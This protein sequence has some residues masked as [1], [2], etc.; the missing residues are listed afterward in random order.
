VYPDIAVVTNVGE[1]HLEGFG[2][3]E[4]VRDTDLE[5]LS[6]VRTACINADDPLLIEGIGTY[7]GR[8]ITYGIENR[9]DFSAREIVPGEEG[10]RFLLV[11][12]DL[13]EVPV[14]LGISGR[15][16]VLNAVAAASAATVLGMN[17]EEI[18]SGL[19]SFRGV[20]MRLEI[21]RLSGALVINDVYNANPA[22]ME[23]ALRELVRLRKGRAIAVLGDMLELG[24]YAPDAHANLVRRLNELSV[25]IL[26]AVGPEMHKA[27]SGF[28]GQAHQAGSSSDARSLLLGMMQEGDTV[29][30]KGSRGMSMEKVLAGDEQAAATEHSNAL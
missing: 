30:I 25:D 1:A 19:E 22:S 6:Y 8:V 18:R 5:V 17:L 26:I 11:T 3:I 28:A 23:G 20:P 2:T 9:A 21:K 16:N 7:Q 13:G 29:L 15:F 10:S 4:T 27:S 12:P 14:S 24:A